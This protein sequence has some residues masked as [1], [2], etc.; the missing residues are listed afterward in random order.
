MLLLDLAWAAR[1]TVG[2]RLVTPGLLIIIMHIDHWFVLTFALWIK[3][4]SQYKNLV[5]GQEK[6]LACSRW[7]NKEV[8]ADNLSPTIYRVAYLYLQCKI[9]IE[10][11]YY[12]WSFTGR[13]TYN[14][15]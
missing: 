14:G 15:F 12:A 9:R 4:S 7:V 5:N 8:L 11:A 2:F 13:P 3:A 1:G 10:H 6:K